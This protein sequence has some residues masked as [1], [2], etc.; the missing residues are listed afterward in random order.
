MSY[1]IKNLPIELQ[2]RLKKAGY[3]DVTKKVNPKEIDGKSCLII[4]H[5]WD[6]YAHNFYE[7]GD[8]DTIAE[9]ISRGSGTEYEKLLDG[10]MI[11]IFSDDAKT[12]KKDY[13]DKDTGGV[14]S[15]RPGVLSIQKDEDSDEDGAIS[16]VIS[17]IYIEHV[18]A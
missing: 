16:V 6:I 4:D 9:I 8:D 18:T 12:Y 7:L 1:T 3:E 15:I 14:W 5:K 13:K 2:K 17:D 10:F 11:W